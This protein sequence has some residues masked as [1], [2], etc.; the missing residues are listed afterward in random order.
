[1]AHTS[2]SES[3]RLAS[4]HVLDAILTSLRAH[5]VPPCAVRATCAHVHTKR[6]LGPCSGLRRRPAGAHARARGEDSAEDRAEAAV[7]AVR[8]AQ[9]PGSIARG[10]TLTP[11][12]SRPARTPQHIGPGHAFERLDRRTRTHSQTFRQANRPDSETR[13]VPAGPRSRRLSPN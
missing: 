2:E 1:M 10:R 6:G 4:N 13:A 11:S 8:G 9:R 7:R 3:T 12:T 5:C